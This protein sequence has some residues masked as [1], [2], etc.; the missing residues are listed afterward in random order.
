LF[1]VTVQRADRA[2]FTETRYDLSIIPK[3][4]YRLTPRIYFSTGMGIAYNELRDENTDE[5]DLA[6]GGN[7]FFAPEASF[8]YDF[9]V[10]K[11]TY[12]VEATFAHRSN[13]RLANN[14]Q[15]LNLMLI[16]L[17]IRFD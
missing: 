12:F 7:L 5:V 3:V 2:G 8:G 13:G 10:S 11:L 4:R 17:G 15:S 16:A 14:N 9:I 1:F 6:L